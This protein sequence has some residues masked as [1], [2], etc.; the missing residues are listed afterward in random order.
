MSLN[1]VNYYFEFS[2]CRFLERIASEAKTTGNEISS[3]ISSNTIFEVVIGRLCYA[4][5]EDDGSTHKPFSQ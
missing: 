4:L 5:N 2:I 3:S 1:C